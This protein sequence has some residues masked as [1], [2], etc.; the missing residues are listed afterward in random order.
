MDVTAA[1]TLL[2][3]LNREVWLVTAQVRSVADSDQQAGGP[4]KSSRSSTRPMSRSGLIATFVSE[5]SIVTNLPRVLVGLAKQ[6]RTCELALASG[7]FA[8]HLLG[9]QNLD[10]VWHFGLQSG[11]HLDKFK[12]MRVQ[13]ASTGSPIL[14]ETIGWL[15]CQVEARLDTGDRLVFLAAVVQSEV[16]HFAPPLTFNRLMELAPPHCLN[17]MKRRRHFD[18]HADARAICAWRTEQGIASDLG[19]FGPDA[20]DESVTRPPGGG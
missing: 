5:A 13:T 2:A 7:A 9:E 10:W 16:N 20:H 18:S 6:H 1:P 15:D 14:S 19:G 8:L 11:R 3:W 17:E 4:G 12:G